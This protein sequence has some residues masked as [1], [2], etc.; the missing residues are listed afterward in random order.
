[1][2]TLRQR[3]LALKQQLELDT[4]S[5]C[6]SQPCAWTVPARKTKIEPMRVKDMNFKAAKFNKGEFLEMCSVYMHE[7]LIIL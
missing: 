4:N 2:R 1:M 3:F 6:T 5:A 7:H